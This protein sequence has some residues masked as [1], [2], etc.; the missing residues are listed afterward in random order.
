MT[1]EM[2]LQ[3]LRIYALEKA[4]ARY[5]NKTAEQ[6]VAFAE[7]L[8]DYL[9]GG[10]EFKGAQEAYK[11]ATEDMKTLLDSSSPVPITRGRRKKPEPLRSPLPDGA[12][13]DAANVVPLAAPQEAQEPDVAPAEDPAAPDPVAQEPDGGFDEEPPV[14]LPRRSLPRRQ[15]QILDVLN[16]MAEQGQLPAT[17]A[18]IASFMDDPSGVAGVYP[19]VI[20]LLQKGYLVKQPAKNGAVFDLAPDSEEEGDDD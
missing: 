5:E 13:K 3:N 14:A 15:Q 9:R 2:S 10:A 17:M 12:P 6:I 1:T 8:F 16:E 11:T 18:E 4:L 19:M 7:T 20:G